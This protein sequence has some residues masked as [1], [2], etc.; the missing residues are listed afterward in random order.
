MADDLQPPPGYEPLNPQPRSFS[1]DILQPPPGYEPLQSN[2][3]LPGSST[4]KVGAD[5]YGK[6]LAQAPPILG[7]SLGPEGTL[8][9]SVVSQ[10]MKAAAPNFFGQAP[11]S[12]GE[13]A[14]SLGVDLLTNEGIPRGLGWAGKAI[15]RNLPAVKEGIASSIGKQLMKRSYP[16]SNIIESAAENAGNN[17]N[18]LSQINPDELSNTF[19]NNAIGNKLVKLNEEYGVG[20]SVAKTQAYKDIS[21]QAY[22]DLTHL[23]NFKL[24]TGEPTT[25]AQLGYN[26]LLGSGDSIDAAAVLKELNGPK[27]E[28]YSEGLGKGIDNFRNLLTEMAKQQETGGPVNSIIRYTGHRLM[29]EGLAG[30]AALTGHP[31]MA[32]AAGAVSLSQPMIAKLMSTKYAPFVVAALK[33]PSSAAEAPLINQFLDVAIKSLGGAGV[34]AAKD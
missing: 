18:T 8:L 28:I 1:R 26:R 25:V 5:F 4:E 11:Q 34:A 10:G 17:Y 2:S 32:A 9:G 15:G 20:P 12:V 13:Y 24:A 16:E 27:S 22:S 19:D 7:S 3:Q 23:R 29:W 14:K 33:T 6:L 30:G 21:N 31:Y